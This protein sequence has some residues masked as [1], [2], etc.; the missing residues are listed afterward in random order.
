MH[1]FT[2]IN[3]SVLIPNNT[4]D[5]LI[6]PYINTAIKLQSIYFNPSSSTKNRL[7]LIWTKNVSFPLKISRSALTKS[8]PLF[9]EQIWR[10]T[11]RYI[12]TSVMIPTNTLDLLIL[13]D[14]KHY[15]HALH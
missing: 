13:G 12:A 3:T 15:I 6:L 1:Y 8:P 11:E 9:L 4:L 5:S 7:M 2:F 10:A 14:S